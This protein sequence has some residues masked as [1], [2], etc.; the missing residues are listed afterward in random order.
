MKDFDDFV[1]KTVALYGVDNNCFKIG[2]KETTH[3]F[4]AVEDPEDGYRSCMQSIEIKDPE[5]LVF[6]KR[7]LAQVE[8]QDAEGIDGYDF[9]DE[10]GHVW[11]T[12]GTDNDDCYYPLFVFRWQAKEPTG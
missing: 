2:F 6:F 5:G 8:I 4:E 9:T 11:L 10:D 7:P 1:G 12:F 3:V